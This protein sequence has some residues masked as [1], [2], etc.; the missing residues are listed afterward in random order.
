[1]K[2][3]LRQK[4]D[5]ALVLYQRLCFLFASLSILYF[6]GAM[7]SLFAEEQALSFTFSL[8]AYLRVI[9]FAEA[10]L[11]N[12][13]WNYFAYVVVAVALCGGTL[14]LS[15]Q[16]AKAKVKRGWPS[17]ILFLADLVFCI[18]LMCRVPDMGWD[19]ST[20]VISLLLHVA[21]ALIILAGAI[22]YARLYALFERK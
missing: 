9:M 17:I 6:L 13:A 11:G 10:Y 3:E 1:M 14:Y 22:A 18:C 7:V 5:K 12:V 15:L 19:M 4:Q 2:D 16:L 21:Y 8:L 20:L